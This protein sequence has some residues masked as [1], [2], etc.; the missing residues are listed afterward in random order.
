[1]ATDTLGVPGG[2]SMSGGL[3]LPSAQTAVRN[4]NIGTS[5][6]L[7]EMNRLVRNVNDNL[8]MEA[9]ALTA[10]AANIND[11]TQAVSRLHKEEVKL[12]GVQAA[13]KK[14]AEIGKSL[15]SAGGQV[16]GLATGAT[17]MLGL[18]GLG[19]S[20]ADV[21]KAI[22]ALTIQRGLTKGESDSIL[23]RL[24]DMARVTNQ[25]VPELLAGLKEL[26]ARDLK[27]DDAMATL[28]DVAQGVTAGMGTMPDFSAVA[29]AFHTNLKVD[30]GPEL[31]RA[32]GVA[33]AGAQ[34]GGFDLSRMAEY[35]P[36]LTGKAS[37]LGM[38][39][40]RGVA[41][42]VA[43]LQAAF[44]E[45]QDYG[46]AAQRVQDLFEKL[47]APNAV[48]GLKKE[49]VD[50]V[51]I[52]AQEGGEP[53]LEALRRIREMQAD[54]EK[55]KVLA[56]L[57]PRANMAELGRPI[58]QNVRQYETSRDAALAGANTIDLGFEAA[59]KGPFEQLKKLR[60]ALQETARPYL[61][62]MLE[63]VNGWLTIINKHPVWQRRL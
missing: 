22:R 13:A 39:G 8:H 19:T 32:L 21:D 43:M 60:I 5:R 7:N 34:E 4:L 11:V 3:W 38:T 45:T 63:R 51:G 40:E 41:Q 46:Q 18:S 9:A 59:M 58:L 14:S 24:S 26:M 50:M 28:P 61:V 52:A 36:K 55:N 42:I 56:D 15:Q 16:M 57:F 23:P 29:A 17:E 2:F 10:I 25:S 27:L 62:D 53:V 37:A 6:W 47:A 33:A 48:A 44:D 12:S 35:L 49:G 1:M 30:V 54:P 20:V 31:K